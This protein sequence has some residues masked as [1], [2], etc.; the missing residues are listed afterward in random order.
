MC[1]PLFYVPEIFHVLFHLL[2]MITCE[3]DNTEI[4][5]FIVLRF[6]AL[7]NT[8]FFTNQRFLA[9]MHQASLFTSFFQQHLLTSSLCVTFW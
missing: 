8:V 4:S 3:V 7:C 5:H 1:H 6:I 9:T 2:P